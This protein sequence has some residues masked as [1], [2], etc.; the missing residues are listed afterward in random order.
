MHFLNFVMSYRT[1]KGMVEPALIWKYVY[2]LVLPFYN[3][4][5]FHPLDWDMIRKKYAKPRRL[6]NLLMC[7]SMAY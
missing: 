1:A 4:S 2:F 5:F 3:F 6:N 7:A